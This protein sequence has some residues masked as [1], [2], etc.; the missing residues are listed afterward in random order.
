MKLGKTVWPTTAVAG[1]NKAPKVPAKAYPAAL[2]K[3]QTPINKEENRFGANFAT[4]DNPIGDKLS[5]PIVWNKY[6][7]NNQI[8]PNL[9]DPKSFTFIAM[10]KYPIAKSN[11]PIACLPGELGSIPF[12]DK[13]I[14]SQEKGKAKMI[15]KKELAFWTELGGNCIPKKFKSVC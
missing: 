15:I 12:F 13:R 1:G 6:M 11:N 5:S 14:Q 2:A 4:S 9:S 8:T 10:I 7:M 3:N